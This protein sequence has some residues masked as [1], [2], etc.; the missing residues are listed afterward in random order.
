M[1]ALQYRNLNKIDENLIELEK[2]YGEIVEKLHY[3]NKSIT[4][5]DKMIPLHKDSEKDLI[6][7]LEPLNTSILVLCNLISIKNE[8]LFTSRFNDKIF[9]LFCFFGQIN[10][11]YSY[12]KKSN[13]LVLVDQILFYYHC[14]MM[15]LKS[16][17]KRKISNKSIEN[18]YSF[19]SIDTNLLKLEE[20]KISDSMSGVD[21]YNDEYKNIYDHLN[22]EPFF[23]KGY[24][25]RSSDMFKLK[26][27]KNKETDENIKDENISGV[28]GK[29]EED[30]NSN[31][32]KN[33]IL[34][35]QVNKSIFMEFEELICQYKLARCEIRSLLEQREF[36]IKG[37]NLV[38]GYIIIEQ[39]LESQSIE[40]NNIIKSINDKG[41]EILFKNDKLNLALNSFSP[42]EKEKLLRLYKDYEHIRNSIKTDVNNLDSV[43]DEL[44]IEYDDIYKIKSNIKDC[45][46][47]DE[48]SK[49]NAN[50]DG[51]NNKFIN[52][53]VNL[54]DE[55]LSHFNTENLKET[56]DTNNRHESKK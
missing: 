54:N 15:L 53:N 49:E 9:N 2:L 39:L 12:F 52:K 33:L 30:Q 50:K 19:L 46:F 3:I 5:G 20:I 24:N 55:G 21:D 28:T 18:Y 11:Y 47:L 31:Y 22:E 10:A 13:N 6:S 23:K 17:N 32:V 34:P 38:D 42:K 44:L 36:E 29:I 40:N 41:N 56:N 43:I 4:I 26:P 1:N 51:Q 14:I 27:T 8:I 37:R 7:S 35:G 48:F 16:S 45:Q 25:K